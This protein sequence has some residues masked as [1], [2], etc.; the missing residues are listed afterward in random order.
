VVKLKN[1]VTI[2]NKE[3]PNHFESLVAA[4]GVEFSCGRSSATVGQF[5]LLCTR[6]Q[7]SVKQTVIYII[8]GD[9]TISEIL[10]RV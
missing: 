8:C 4:S 3:W 7:C 2:I 10:E 5:S 9:L 1:L 6:L